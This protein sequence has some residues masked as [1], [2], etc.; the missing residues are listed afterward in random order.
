MADEDAERQRLRR[1][2]VVRRFI[3]VGVV[4]AAAVIAARFVWAR[5]ALVESVASDDGIY[6]ADL[7]H[8]WHFM[9]TVVEV[10]VVRVDGLVNR[11]VGRI[12]TS[13]VDYDFALERT[14]HTLR[15]VYPSGRLI[16]AG[17]V[18]RNEVTWS[19]QAFTS[20]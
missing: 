1:S 12:C 10:K 7:S 20:C 6:R 2:S 9:E 17:R 15:L 16:G 4:V 19:A 8:P 14:G 3:V 13:S 18:Q 11:E 5:V